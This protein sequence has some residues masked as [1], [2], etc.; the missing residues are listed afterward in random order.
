[1]REAR[2]DRI[3]QAHE[4]VAKCFDTGVSTHEAAK[5]FHYIIS[6]APQ[7]MCFPVFLSLIRSGLV[8]NIRLEARSGPPPAHVPNPDLVK[9]YD[10]IIDAILP[11][12]PVAAQRAV[13]TYLEGSLE[14]S[15]DLS[16][17]RGARPG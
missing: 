1:M 14:R 12:D 16:G 17:V 5:A 3:A 13:Q 9:E 10:L 8:P 6:E 15:R 2:I 7:S 11:G 4:E